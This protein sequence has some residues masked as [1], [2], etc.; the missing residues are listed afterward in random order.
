MK[1][2]KED[3]QYYKVMQDGRFIMFGELKYD[4]D[5]LNIIDEIVFITKE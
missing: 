1:Y 2:T 3:G 4:Y 5:E